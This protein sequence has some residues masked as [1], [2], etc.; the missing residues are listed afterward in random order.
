MEN[1]IKGSV[2]KLPKMLPSRKENSVN[3]G[4]N[5]ISNI[6]LKLYVCKWKDF[7]EILIMREEWK[8]VWNWKNRWTSEKKGLLKI[9]CP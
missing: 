5:I 9:R 7:V 3:Y 2:N 4:V 8:P 1:L 6:C